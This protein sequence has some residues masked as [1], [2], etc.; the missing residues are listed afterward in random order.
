[1]TTGFLGLILDTSATIVNLTVVIVASN[2]SQRVS[3][4]SSLPNCSSSS[5][6]ESSP[7]SA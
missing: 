1:M 2:S 6:A 7:R 3:P 4:R 5:R